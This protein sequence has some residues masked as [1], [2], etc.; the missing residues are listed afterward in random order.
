M[1]CE[2]STE[3]IKKFL[4]KDLKKTLMKIKKVLLNAM[5]L[6]DVRKTIVS[7]LRNG[8]IKS[9]E[10]WSAAKSKSE[11]SIAE[12]KKIKKT[13]IWWNCWKRKEDKT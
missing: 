10:F 1:K 11:E 8:F 5:M 6:F 9:L 13:K 2:K 7:L 3:E 12:R 4:S